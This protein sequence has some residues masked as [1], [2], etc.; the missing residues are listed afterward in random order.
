MALIFD[1]SKDL[2]RKLKSSYCCRLRSR[3]KDHREESKFFT[4]KNLVDLKTAVEYGTESLTSL[5]R[6]CF[7][8]F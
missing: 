3:N 6:F 7:V 5:K 2:I 8:L 1:P 4:F